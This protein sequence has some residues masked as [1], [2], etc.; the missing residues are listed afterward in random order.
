[1]MTCNKLIT[2]FALYRGFDLAVIGCGTTPDDL[3][4]LVK[5]GLIVQL[6]DKTR[7]DG[8]YLTELGRSKVPAM[9][10]LMS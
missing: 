6:E 5:R 4:Y 1:M 10:N 2:L 9:I 8:W 7:N 3:L